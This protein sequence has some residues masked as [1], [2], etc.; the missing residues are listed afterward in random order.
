LENKVEPE[1]CLSLKE[2]SKIYDCHEISEKVE[3]VIRKNFEIVVS[4]D[5]FK[6]LELKE[7]KSLLELNRVK[8]STTDEFDKQVKLI[9][10]DDLLLSLVPLLRSCLNVKDIISLTEELVRTHYFENLIISPN[11]VK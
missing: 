7:V 1:N 9:K 8:P 5:E 2:F 4:S 11:L 3:D 6:A 10:I